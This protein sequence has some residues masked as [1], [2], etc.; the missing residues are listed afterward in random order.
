M[1]TIPVIDKVN[2]RHVNEALHKSN[3]SYCWCYYLYREDFPVIENLHIPTPYLRKAATCCYKSLRHKVN[4]MLHKIP[5]GRA[6]T[7]TIPAG[8]D[9]VKSILIRK[10]YSKG[11]RKFHLRKNWII[12]KS[13][14]KSVW[15]KFILFFRGRDNICIPSRICFRTKSVCADKEESDE[16]YGFHNISAACN[17]GERTEFYA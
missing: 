6:A 16:E 11:G 10:N 5:R 12:A 7:T 1:S 13:Q 15:I 8:T 4:H 3:S 14:Y 17:R 2:P 9:H